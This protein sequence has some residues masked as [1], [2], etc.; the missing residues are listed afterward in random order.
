MKKIICLLT[1]SGLTTITTT[2]T[3]PM[4]KVTVTKYE[5]YCGKCGR[6]LKRSH[7]R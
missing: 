2:D 7:R 3:N 4:T 5:W 1:H 6:E